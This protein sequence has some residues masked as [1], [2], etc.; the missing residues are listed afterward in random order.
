MYTD[1]IRAVE[2]YE[3]MILETERYIWRNPETGY[4]EIKTS[5]YMERL[6]ESLGYSLV[7]AENIPGFYTVLDTGRPGPTILVFGELDSLVCS[8]HPESDPDTGAVHCCGHN[9]QCAALAGLAAALK[10]QGI[11][12]GLCGK[13]K[14]C[15]VPAEELIEIEYRSSLMEQGIIRYFGG[16]VEFMYRGFFDD[17]DMAFMLHTSVDD[18]FSYGLGNVG[19]IA[20]NIFYKGVSA[21]AG[22]SP[23]EGV[24]ALY[25]ASLGLQGVNALR[26][27]FREED[28]LR[29]HPIITKGGSA[30]NAIPEDVRVE[31]YVRGKTLDVIEQTNKKVNR[32]LISGALSLGAQ[33]DIV[34]RSGYAPLNNDLGLGEVFKNAAEAAGQS[35]SFSNAFGTGCTDMGDLSSVM[36]VIHPYAGGASGTSH[37][38]DYYIA[39]PKLACVESA[40]VQLI[41]LKTLLSDGAARAKEIIANFKPFFASKKDYFIKMDSLN[42]QGDRIEYKDD[43]TV[44]I[45]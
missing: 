25:A 17:V 11:T 23:H 39:N 2:K 14:L 3:K 10:E 20:K 29:V 36:P 32:A 13:I 21:H 37:G 15:V 45:Y 35:C 42:R 41:M 22:G 1:A 7:K 4:K 40:K 12:D 16:K 24:N 8:E 5:A 44:R 30:V 28:L 33:I 34:D 6:F 18:E 43:D 31:S 19:C 38:K 27:T 26:E 9:A